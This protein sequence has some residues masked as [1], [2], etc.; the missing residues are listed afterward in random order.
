[1]SVDEF[2]AERGLGR[3]DFIKLDVEG[4]EGPVLQGAR[5]SLER[6]RPQLAISIYHGKRDFW[7]L[8][9]LLGELPG[10]AHFLGHYSEKFFETIWYAIPEEMLS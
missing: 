8:P 9:Q 3:L 2:V 4:A 6:L 10:Y 1:M 7:A 5:A